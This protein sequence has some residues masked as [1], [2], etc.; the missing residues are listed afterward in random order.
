MDLVVF[1]AVLFAAACHAAWNASIK[2]T[3][4]PLATTVLIALGAGLVALPGIAWA[5]L[6]APASL[7]W[8]VA[9]VVIHIFYFAGLIESYRA[10][11][12]GQ[13]YPIARGAA[14]LMTATLTTAVRRRTAWRRRL[15]RHCPAGRRRAA[16]VVA[17][18]PRSRH[19]RP[20]RGR[21]CV[22]HRGVHLHLLGGRWH[23]RACGRAGPRQR[24]YA[25]AVRWHCADR[26]GSTRWHGAAAQFCRRWCRTGRS[27]SAAARWR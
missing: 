1:L 8:L 26:A 19:A 13:V 16:A 20:P 25:G 7:P 15:E 3:L 2:G 5:G 24:L 6:P 9:S 18:R 11:D 10:G 4:D 14:P 22:V 21:L 12:L 23:R 27:G 17:R